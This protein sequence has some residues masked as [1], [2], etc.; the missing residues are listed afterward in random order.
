MD[1][2]ANGHTGVPAWDLPVLGRGNPG[3]PGQ[4]PLRLAPVRGLGLPGTEQVHVC[5]S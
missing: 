5:I 1:S 4:P 3:G 2:D